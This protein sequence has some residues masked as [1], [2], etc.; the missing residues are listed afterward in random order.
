METTYNRLAGQSI[1]RLSGLSDSVFGFAMTLL[2]VAL[3]TPISEAIH[4]EHALC[5]RCQ[6]W[7][8]SR[9]RI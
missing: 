2:V 7:R 9:F 6:Q 1:G 4:S 3:P 8:R 5:W